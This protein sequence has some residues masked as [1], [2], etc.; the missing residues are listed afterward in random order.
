MQDESEWLQ[1]VKEYTSKA[2][3][4]ANPDSKGEFEIAEMFTMMMQLDNLVSLRIRRLD[5]YKKHLD[6][7][8]I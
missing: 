2:R 1:I 8:K 5:V 4:Y 6:E 3:D 7:R